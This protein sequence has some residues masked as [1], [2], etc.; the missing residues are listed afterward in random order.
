MT[1]KVTVSLTDIEAQ[2]WQYAVR[3]LAGFVPA[4]GDDVQKKLVA[5]APFKAAEFFIGRRFN[6]NRPSVE[7]LCILLAAATIIRDTEIREKLVGIMEHVFK[8]RGLIPQ[9]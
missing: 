8:Q 2:E 4:T 9:S 6:F 5:Q 3:H 1:E 7:Q